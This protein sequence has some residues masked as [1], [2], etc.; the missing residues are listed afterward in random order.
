MSN[1]ER[2]RGFAP[3][4]DDVLDRLATL[5]ALLAESRV[6]LAYLFG[7]LVDPASAGRPPNDVDLALLTA[8]DRPPFYLRELI[9][10]HLGT[11]R[12]DIVDL[13]RASPP[14]RFAVISEGRLLYAADEDDRL[15]F[16]LRTLRDYRDTAHI[17][18]RRK[19]LLK[20]RMARWS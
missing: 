9:V 11:E 10:E 20:E 13:R 7:S 1:P 12:L 18:R 19:E 2:W 16:E 14:L 15:A 8:R 5:P 4:P 6:E 17:R 3:L